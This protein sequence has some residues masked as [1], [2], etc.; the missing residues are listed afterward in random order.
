MNDSMLIL[1]FQ[2]TRRLRANALGRLVKTAFRKGTQPER[3]YCVGR[4]PMDMLTWRQH[5]CH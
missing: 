5:V 2:F 1:T 4:D 3:D